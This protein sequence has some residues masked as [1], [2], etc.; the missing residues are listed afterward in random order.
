MCL[1][2]VQHI[3]IVTNAS[4]VGRR[5]IGAKNRQGRQS[6]QGGQQ[7]PWNQMG[8]RLM[9]LTDQ[10]IL[11]PTAGIEITQHHRAQPPGRFTLPQSTFQHQ[12]AGSIGIDGLLRM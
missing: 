4:A 6:A 2:E 11:R 7:G 10:A 3:D 12:L 9:I 8:F 5:K 1:C